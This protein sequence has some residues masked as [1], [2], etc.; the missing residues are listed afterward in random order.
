M[1]SQKFIKTFNVGLIV[2]MLL[3]FML[4]VVTLYS[5]ARGPGLYSL[6]K[7]QF[8]YF[9]LGLVMIA[10]LVFIDSEILEKVSYLSYG[11]VL[12]MLGLVL[13]I[14]HDAKGSSRWFNLG[15]FHLQPSEL[16]KVSI[17]MTLAK[18]F[19]DEKQGGP[20]NL[21]RL[22]IPAAFILPYFLLIL[23]Q[24]DMGTGGIVFLTAGALILFVKVDWRSL[25]IVA[26]LGII[27][28]PLAYQF[29]LHDYQ[30]E[31]VKTFM[32]PERDPK[33]TGYNAMQCKIAVGSGKT[34]GKGYLK[35]TQ[36]QLN[37]IPEQQTDF[38]F[39]VF[40]EERGFFGAIIL[41]CLYG[42][43]CFYSFRTVARA[44]G[45]YEML[46]AFGLT[47]IMFWHVFINMGMVIGVLPIVGVTLPFF[48]YGGSSL[49][50]FML[51]TGLLLNIS[52]KRY[53]F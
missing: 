14:G 37:F 38:I 36:S 10:I 23:K 17:V 13:V 27:T 9:G 31:R 11:V 49:L 30:R 12:I 26:L 28:V 22:M 16:A 50:T 7:S 4:G 19:S 33:D 5:A 29:V 47:A 8:I 52:R 34:F 18:Y 39:S 25:L 3:L 41:L 24:P 15:F 44:R 6:Y 1:E 48:S 53:I 46:L 51:I 45:K 42:A 40:A 43:Y 32:D 20:Y 21:K 35:G 2:S